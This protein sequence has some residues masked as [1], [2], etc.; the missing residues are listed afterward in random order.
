MRVGTSSRLAVRLQACRPVTAARKGRAGQDNAG[1]AHESPTSPSSP[2]RQKH[3]DHSG[4]RWELRAPLDASSHDVRMRRGCDGDLSLEVRNL[5]SLQR[6]SGSGVGPAPSYAFPASQHWSTC[7]IE[8]TRN[9]VGL[10]G[11][12]SHGSVS[13]T[14]RQGILL[15]PRSGQQVL[16]QRTRLVSWGLPCRRGLFCFG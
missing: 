6:C 2:R 5:A 16:G 13:T 10:I 1:C 11:R 14:A 9:L 15:W 8:R 4:C 12:A 7:T 3:D